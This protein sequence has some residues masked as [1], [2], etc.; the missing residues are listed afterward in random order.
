[1]TTRGVLVRVVGLC[2]AALVSGCTAERTLPAVRD[3]G[4]RA[5]M[6]GDYA[7]AEADYREVVTREPGDWKA[8]QNLGKTLMI[9][10]RPREAREHLAVAQN[11]RPDDG[12]TI[13]LLAQ[14]M[15]ES[16]DRDG[17]FRLLRSRAEERRT[18]E[19]YQRFGRF[20][21]KAGDNDE[22]ERAFLTAA[23][24]DGGR[25]FEVQKSLGDF[26]QSI[27]AEEKALKRYRMALYL[28]PDDKDVADRIR[29]L[30]KVP[31]PSYVLRPEEAPE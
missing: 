25:S 28:K 23:R 27:G 29:A 5:Y 13:E 6:K 9:L 18:V 16:G 30:G 12:E 10:D 21:S 14:A 22:A 24:F 19:D 8:R 20:A 31:G 15:L 11:V 3:S 7:R 17:M 1:M 4:D 2:A 26:Y